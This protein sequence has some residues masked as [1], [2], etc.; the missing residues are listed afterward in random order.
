LD[1]HRDPSAKDAAIAST[2]QT[3]SM[4]DRPGQIW[5]RRASLAALLLLWLSSG[6]P[7]QAQEDPAIPDSC[8]NGV[9]DD[10]DGNTDCC[11]SDCVGDPDCIEIC[12][13]GLDDDCDG[14]IDLQD[15][16][17]YGMPTPGY[18]SRGDANGDGQHD[19]ADPILML[20]HLFLDMTVPCL[21]SVDVNDDGAANIADPI[22]LLQCLFIFCDVTVIAPPYPDCGFDP[23]DDDFHCWDYF[24]CP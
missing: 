2:Q 14:L 11:D 13:N 22:S 19:I 3:T 20:G 17:C 7:L 23:T 21:D 10:G 24:G 8:S 18:F 6:L 4:A 16:N 1:P 12:D 15:S 9:D 5:C